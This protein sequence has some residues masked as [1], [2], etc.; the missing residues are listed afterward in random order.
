MLLTNLSYETCRLVQSYDAHVVMIVDIYSRH[1]MV[2]NIKWF[3]HTHGLVLLSTNGVDK[4]EVS[5][6]MEN[7]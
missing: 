4:A 2:K 7:C 6:D 1:V 3:P 5:Q